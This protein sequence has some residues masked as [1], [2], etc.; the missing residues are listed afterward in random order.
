MKT[1]RL[2][3]LTLLL[4][5]SPV[6]AMDMKVVGNQL[7]LS[8]AVDGLDYQKFLRMLTPSVQM[9]VLSNSP[10]GDLRSGLDIAREIR[11]RGLPTVA[12]GFCQSSCANIFLG[13]RERFLANNSSYLGFHGN[14]QTRR[15]VPSSA[16]IGELKVF[17]SEMTGGKLSDEMVELFVGKQRGGYIAFF[18]H[19][20]RN[21]I[22]TEAHRPRDCENLPQTAIE[23]GILTSLDDIKINAQALATEQRGAEIDH[24]SK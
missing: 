1:L 3:T 24:D 18:K 14:Y 21:C 4:F 11:S 5:S 9:V 19:I 12:S 23:Q 16:R 7:V 2:L 17:Y 22:G 10:G 15:T 13:G 8:G 20:A 6:G